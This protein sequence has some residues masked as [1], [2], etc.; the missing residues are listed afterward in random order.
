M[1]NEQIGY[2]LTDL[3]V[4]GLTDWQVEKLTGRW[5]DRSID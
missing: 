4:D 1:K 2:L 5:I 3:Q